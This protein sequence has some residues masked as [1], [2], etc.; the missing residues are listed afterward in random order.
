MEPH[1][2][3]GTP[4]QVAIPADKR[5]KGTKFVA[6][7][8]YETLPSSSAIQWLTKEQ[9][10]DKTHPYMFTQ[11]Q[12]IHARSLLPCQDCPSIKTSYTAYVAAPGWSQCMMSAVSDGS[13]ELDTEGYRIFKWK[14]S[15]Q[16]PA[17][18]IAIVAGRVESRDIGPRTRVWAE[19]SVVEAAAFDFAQTEEFICHAESIM[20][21]EYV[22]GRYDLVCLPPSFPYGGMENPCLTFVTPTL[23]TGD[24]SL[25]DVIAHEIAHSWTGNLIT[26]HTWEHFWLNEGWT[27]WLQRKI[28]SRIHSPEYFDFDSIIGWKHLSDSVDVYGEQHPFT[29][30][31]PTIAGVDPDDSFSSVPYEKGFNFLYYMSK[32]VGSENFDE[33]AKAYVQK[34]KYGTVT[35]DQFCS[36][37]RAHFD[38]RNID[39]SQVDWDAWI[40]KPGMPPVTPDFDQTLSNDCTAVAN[41]WLLNEEC[42]L[43]T[44]KSWTSSQYVVMLEK[45]LTDLGQEKELPESTLKRM[46]EIYEF[47]KTRNAEIR[48]CWQ[49]LCLRS[50]VSFIFEQVEAFLKEQGRMKFV[51]P[52]FR[53]LQQT[54]EGKKLANRIFSEWKMNYHPIAQKMIAKDLEQA[55]A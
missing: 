14:Q 15:V 44:S 3:F 39:Y 10:A 13:S 36:F 55:A 45:I 30:L 37:F 1:Q 43:A 21:Q 33:F 11:C 47:S 54:D 42:T 51:R 34:F 38:A 12:A 8:E 9:T 23:L 7:L 20:D 49:K 24:R 50:H 4:I 41:R 35:T 16:I 22:W 32:I 5:S 17:Y 53:E 29:L 25:A 26:N 46:E 52:L 18:L 27:V 2:V 31:V 19:P 6:K 40:S 28:M 48:F